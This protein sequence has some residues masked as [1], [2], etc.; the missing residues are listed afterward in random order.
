MQL[1]HGVDIYAS[2][3]SNSLS[4]Q[5]AVQPLLTWGAKGSAEGQF[6]D[7]AIIAHHE[8]VDQS[9]QERGDNRNSEKRPTSINL[10]HGHVR[11]W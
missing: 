10:L 11:G 8:R 4:R 5:P 6:K 3:R 1:A 2:K 7:W 9:E